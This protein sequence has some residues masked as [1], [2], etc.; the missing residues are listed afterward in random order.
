MRKNVTNFLDQQADFVIELQKNMTAIPA[1]GPDNKGDG[2][3]E[4]AACLLGALKKLGL[5]EIREINA[6]DKRVSSGVRPNIAARLPGK[7][8]RTLWVIGHLDVVPA[9]DETLW[10]SPPHHLRQEGDLLYG[11]GVED[12]QQAIVTGLL[13]MKA[14]RELGLEPDLSLGLLMVSDEETHSAYGLGHVVESAPD[15]IKP[16]DLVLIPDIGDRHGKYVEVAEKSMLWIKVSVI[17]RQC[18]A[19]TPDKGVNTLFASSAA[20]LAL[21]ELHRAFP[22]KDALFRPAGSTF[23]PT[24]KDANVEN[25]NTIAGLDV[26]YLDCRVLPG[27]DLHEVLRKTE[28]IVSAAVKPYQA[29]CKV[30]VLFQEVAPPATSPEAPV[31]LRLARSLKKLRGLEPTPI[32]VGGQT[33]AAILRAR[34]I[35]VAAWSTVLGSAHAP[36]ERSSITNNL[37][38]A[39]VVVDMLFD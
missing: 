21:D 26:F 7:S 6:P 5:G 24:K 15:L 3:S 36:N 13:A 37:A 20:V 19:S 32:G 23:V 11:R 1:I 27:I 29:G 35:P 8:A 39:K 31:V 17:G 22:Q 33:V 9:G 38:D 10:E 4:K 30:E 14:V 28:Q 2:E 12:N 16:D 18:H 25:I 34:G